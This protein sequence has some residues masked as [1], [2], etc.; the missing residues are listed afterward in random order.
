MDRGEFGDAVSVFTRLIE[1]RPDYAEGWNKRATAYFLMREMENSV[2]DIERTLAL[3]PR[4]FG[5][6]SGMGLIFLSRE[7]FHGALDAFRQ[8][9]KI[10]PRSISAHIH[11]ERIEKLLQGRAV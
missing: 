2:A 7:D 1:L 9:L 5:A 3:E 6:L 10:Y 4:H 11:V 8:V